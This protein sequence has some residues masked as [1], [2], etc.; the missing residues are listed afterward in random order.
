M[1]FES[2]VP[3]H[4]PLV[5]LAVTCEMGSSLVTRTYL[6]FQNAGVLVIEKGLGDHYNLSYKDHFSRL[7]KAARR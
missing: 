5:V 1:L 7:P 2:D 4:N 6:R 3:E